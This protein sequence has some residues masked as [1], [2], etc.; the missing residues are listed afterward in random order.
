MTELKTLK[1][2]VM[3]KD[4]CPSS[5]SEWV[6]FDELRQETIK[7][8]KEKFMG[9]STHGNCCSC[10]DCRNYH[11]DCKCDIIKEFKDFFNI[12]EED[13]KGGRK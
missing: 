8:I 12:T 6:D 7:R 4:T 11:D 9:N 1:D 10:T 2:L 13:L 3:D 5:Q